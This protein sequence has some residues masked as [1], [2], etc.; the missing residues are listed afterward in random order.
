V[1]NEEAR[2]ALIELEIVNDRTKV[3]EAAKTK[4]AAA[5]ETAQADAEATTIRGGAERTIE[6]ER[7]DALTGLLDSP[8]GKAFIELERAK[9]LKATDKVVVPTDSKLVLGLNG[10]ILDN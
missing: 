1:K 6:I 3:L 2:K 10:T 5:L 8:G 9:V 4:A 7:L